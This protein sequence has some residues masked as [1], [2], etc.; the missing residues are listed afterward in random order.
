MNY[1]LE[2]NGKTLLFIHGL[3]DNLLYWEFLTSN[4]KHE[5]QILRVDLRGH[6]QSELGKEE[7]TIDTYVD[8]LNN[9]LEQLNIQKVNIIG[10]SLGGAVALDF[11][12]RYAHKVDSIVMM[13]SFFKTD[14]ESRKILLQLKN[15]LNIG[16]EEFY[17]T[18]L[19]MVLCP[20]VIDENKMELELLKEISSKDANTEAYINAV[21]VCLN[22]NAE[23][24]LSKIR[25]PTLILAGKYDEIYTLSM[26]KELCDKIE[27][28]Q[29]VV[30]DDVKHNL[31][32]G[33][34]N[35][36]ILSALK[37]FFKIS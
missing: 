9:L 15:A 18:I 31:L 28:S 23:K 2:G 27:N 30:F 32:V 22:F 7:I 20:E 11:A 19:P 14:G 24:E 34:T 1:K 6:G 21:D 13:S 25:V 3:S 29:L 4:L 16:F 33:K 12:V 36:K 37:E 8:D 5:Y 17:D 26:Q 35:A 10:F